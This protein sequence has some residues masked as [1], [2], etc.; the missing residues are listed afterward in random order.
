MAQLPTKV[1]LPSRLC[2]WCT[3]QVSMSSLGCGIQTG[4][5]KS[6]DKTVVRGDDVLTF[7]SNACGKLYSLKRSTLPV[8]QRPNEKTFVEGEDAFDTLFSET[9]AGKHVP[10][11]VFV[12]VETRLWMARVRAGAGRPFESERPTSGKEDA[13]DISHVDT[14][15]TG[16]RSCALSWNARGNWWRTALAFKV[17]WLTIRVLEVPGSG[18]RCM[19]LRSCTTF[20]AVNWTSCSKHTRSCTACSHR[21][22]PLHGLSQFSTV[23]CTWTSMSSRR[24]S[25]PASARTS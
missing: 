14:T 21:S 7:T 5:K 2:T 23:R 1:T 20:T 16:G 6:C 18:L 9:S 8:G 15:P 24:I 4:G 12:D 25:S 19:L 22:L 10:R 17:S 11:A 13:A 3:C